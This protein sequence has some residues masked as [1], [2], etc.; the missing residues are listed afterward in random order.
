MSTTEDQIVLW[1][2]GF[3]DE[4][5][6]QS[7]TISIREVLCFFN[8]DSFL[9]HINSWRGGVRSFNY[10]WNRISTTKSHQG[11]ISIYP[12]STGGSENNLA[13]IISPTINRYITP[14]TKEISINI[15]FCLENFKTLNNCFVIFLGENHKYRDV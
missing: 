9:P 15:I 1:K 4:F 2:F 14:D 8:S 7:P 3:Y 12:L 10:S 5:S 13:S 6:S 11:I